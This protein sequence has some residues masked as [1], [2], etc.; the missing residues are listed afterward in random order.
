MRHSESYPLVAHILGERQRR[1]SP[2]SDV[3]WGKWASSKWAVPLPGCVT[4]SKC[5]RLSGP[6]LCNGDADIPTLMGLFWWLNEPVRVQC[7][8][9]TWHEVAAVVIMVVISIFIKKFHIGWW[10]SLDSF[11]LPSP[12]PGTN[13]SCF[14]STSWSVLAPW[15]CWNSSVPPPR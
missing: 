9:S 13:H 6:H 4:Y 11:R 7:L 8:N 15:S 5:L 3:R 2:R 10:R 1:D 14:I 12:T